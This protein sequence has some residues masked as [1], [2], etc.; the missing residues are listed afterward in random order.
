MGIHGINAKSLV[1]VT[2]KLPILFLTRALI[3]ERRHLYHVQILAHLNESDRY[4]LLNDEDKIDV[5]FPIQMKQAR[6]FESRFWI[7]NPL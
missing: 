4:I 1:F 7:F 3:V 6:V 2:E 5:K